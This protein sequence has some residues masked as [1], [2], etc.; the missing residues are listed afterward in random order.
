MYSG[1]AKNDRYITDIQSPCNVNT[2]NSNTQ[3][4]SNTKIKVQNLNEIT[5]QY[6]TAWYPHKSKS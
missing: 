1:N 4:M 5:Q 3:Q 2:D 6:L